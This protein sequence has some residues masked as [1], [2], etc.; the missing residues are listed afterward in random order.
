MTQ[1]GSPRRRV[2][3]SSEMRLVGYQAEVR[4]DHCQTSLQMMLFGSVVL[5]TDHK[6]SPH[7]HLTVLRALQLDLRAA[8]DQGTGILTRSRRGKPDR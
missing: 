6:N 8:K 7:K 1:L 3:T 4:L 2:N 5:A